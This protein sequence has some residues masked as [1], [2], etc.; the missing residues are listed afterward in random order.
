MVAARHDRRVSEVLVT[1]GAAEAFSL[2]ARAL[3]PGV[4]IRYPVVV[5]PQFTEPEVAL[6]TAGHQVRRV[7]LR[8]DDGFRFSASAVPERADLVVIGNPT[9]PTSVLHPV[10][11]LRKLV[12]PGRVLLVD[13]AF[14]DAVPGEPESLA[15]VD[16]PGLI[17]VRSLTKTWGIAGLRAGYLVSDEPLV[18]RLAEQQPP[19]SVSTLASTAVV[20]CLEPP[21]LR[22]AEEMAI[23]TEQHRGLLIDGL[24]R[25]GL[26][27]VE[28]A[29]GPF[30]LVEVG[31]EGDRIRHDLRRAGYAVRRGDSFPGLGPQWIRLAVREPAV[32][33]EF[34]PALAAALSPG[35]DPDLPVP[36]SVSVSAPGGA[37]SAP[38]GSAE[39]GLPGAGC[40]VRCRPGS[41]L[42]PG[43]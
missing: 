25:L 28:P 9:N 26:P 16:L 6:A 12:R 35:S 21:A 2:V 22:L 37:G 38:T 5:H 19:W 23:E 10:E 1:A 15:G 36:V 3:R 13:E 39:T 41:G 17:V 30:V 40:Q 7:L 24:R 43:T 18:A 27:V 14:L 32:T 34:L 29:R 11:E 42:P 31:A 20:A 33:A 4:D 8:A